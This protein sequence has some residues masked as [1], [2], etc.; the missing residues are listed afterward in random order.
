MTPAFSQLSMSRSAIL[1]W[2]VLTCVLAG[3]GTGTAR[4][5]ETVRVGV[6]LSMTG[7]F[8]DYGAVNF[9]GIKLFADNANAQAAERGI[10]YELVLRDDQS[11]ADT[12]A[13][14][15]RELAE[16]GIQVVI[17]PVTSPIM[18]AMSEVTKQYPLV[19]ISPGATSPKIDNSHRWCFKVLPGDDYQGVALAQ[20][21][22]RQMGTTRAAVL[23]NDH[24]DYGRH[25]ANA[26]ST[27]YRRLGGEITVHE[28]YDWDLGPQSIPDFAAILE[29]IRP[30]APE[31]ILLPGYAKEAV[32]C[33][34]QAEG[35]D[36][37]AIFVGGDSWVNHQDI[38]Q[39]G[40]RLHDSYYIGNGEIYSGT[41]EARRFGA[42][43]DAS[44]DPNLQPYSIDGYDSMLLVAHAV[45][46]GARTA[47]EIREKL[48]T[49]R[50][51]PLATG[52]ITFDEESGVAKTMYIYR[53]LA[54][55]G[56]LYAEMVARHDPE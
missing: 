12:A 45:E 35:Q 10:R 28:S 7:E 13:V 5:V 2:I 54:V 23:V 3:A 40:P 18:L 14:I 16:D 56:E 41:A 48:L 36:I 49:L 33:I 8:S 50:R 19:L 53:I 39:A 26:F 37:D 11:D 1:L 55:N 46:S 21:F 43:M 47:E 34:R 20:F 22:A 44:D 15:T 31:V 32:E 4:D 24:F 38:F 9:A 29:K 30:S 27:V 52:S 6:C 51:F 17:G 25:L 42:L